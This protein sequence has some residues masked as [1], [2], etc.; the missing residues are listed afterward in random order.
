[1]AK[2]SKA[3]SKMR[4]DHSVVMGEMSHSDSEAL[5]YTTYWKPDNYKTRKKYFDE[6]MSGSKFD[7]LLR[8]FFF[9]ALDEK[10]KRLF[11][12]QDDWD[13]LKDATSLHPAVLSIAA[14]MVGGS[15]D[16]MFPEEEE[17]QEAA[18]KN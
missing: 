14:E 16:E 12:S 5:G 10:G 4:T 7:A 6:L 3:A 13:I 18:A 2:L 17:G 1:M 9:R 15:V 11:I 8:C